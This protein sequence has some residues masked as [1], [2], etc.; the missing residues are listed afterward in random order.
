MFN[1]FLGDAPSSVSIE[2]YDQKNNELRVSEKIDQL[3][4]GQIGAFKLQNSLKI[5][6]DL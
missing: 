4:S 6:P 3:V 5:N 1:Y 2:I